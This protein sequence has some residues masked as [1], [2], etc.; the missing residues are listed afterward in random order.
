[1]ALVFAVVAG[2]LLGLLT[3]GSLRHFARMRF[4]YLPLLVG[5]LVVQV[6][7]FSPILG[8]REII[9]Q[10]G[11]YI[12]IGTMAA[13][14]FVI[15]ANASIPGLKL[16]GLGA[17][18]NFIVIV[19][20]G[21][22][23]PSPASALERAGMLDH[24]R[25]EEAERASGSYVLTNS[26]IADDDTRLLFLGDVLAMPAWMP[27]A[28]VVSIGDILIALGAMYTIVAV[29]RGRGVREPGLGDRG[30]GTGDRNVMEPGS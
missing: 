5:A 6:L 1:V 29:M 15:V 20:N 3:G 23:M 13:T 25:A 26:T 18:L 8:R 16:I 21:G 22:F 9:H 12:Y 19:A 10:I 2:V 7:I 14:L 4:R 27:Q 28:N 17:A 24:V 30:Q 11:P